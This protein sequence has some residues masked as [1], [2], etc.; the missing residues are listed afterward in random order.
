[1]HWRSAFVAG[2]QIVYDLDGNVVFNDE[3]ATERESLRQN[4]TDLVYDTVGRKTK[5]TLPAGS[6]AC[7]TRHA[8]RYHLSI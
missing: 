8:P 4:Q 1:M 6:T 2:N 7:P 3:S 5:E